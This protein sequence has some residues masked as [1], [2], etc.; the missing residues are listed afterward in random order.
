M[1]VNSKFLKDFIFSDIHSNYLKKSSGCYCSHECGIGVTIMSDK[2]L[3]N[4]LVR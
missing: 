4:E 2:K 3:L 1:I